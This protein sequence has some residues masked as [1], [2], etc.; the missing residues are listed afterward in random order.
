MKFR[1]FWTALF[2]ISTFLVSTSEAKLVFVTEENS[3]NENNFIINGD[4]SSSDFVDLEF[5]SALGVKMRYD[6]LNNRFRINRDLDLEGNQILQTR[7]EN[8]AAA[9]TCDGTTIGLIYYNTTDSKTYVCDGTVFNVLE[10]GAATIGND[11]IFFAYDAAGGTA[12][13]STPTDITFDTEVR[14]DSEYS[15]TGNSGDIT[16]N[17]SGNYIIKY[18]CTMDAIGTARYTVNHWL[19][20]DSGNGFSEIGGTRSG[21]YHRITNDALDNANI[22]RYISLNSGD[23]IKVRASADTNGVI[24]TMPNSCRL[25]IKRVDNAGGLI[26]PQ[27]PTGPTGP[28]GLSGGGWS[29]DG[30]TTSTSQNAQIDG[31]L[32]VNGDIVSECGPYAIFTFER[33]TIV[34][35]QSWAIGNGQ[36]PYGTPMGCDG[37]VKKIAAVCTG[38]IGT[39]LT[40]VL[41][42]NNVAT[43]CSVN[44]AASVGTA[45]IVNCSENFLSTDVLGIYAGTEVGSWTECIGTMWAKYN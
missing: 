40:A 43:T 3:I 24:L 34:S 42:K 45:T 33:G 36:T 20:L 13:A 5:G 9:P 16:I 38:S 11:D 41:R 14:K 4:D 44:I 19:E 22:E 35:N 1:Y 30:T 6:L 18:Q 12:I 26:G 27:G 21:S 2:L 25:E 8:L 29:T 31:N 32:N 15:H 28:S 23:I 17:T 10:T 39:S 7:L 37:Q